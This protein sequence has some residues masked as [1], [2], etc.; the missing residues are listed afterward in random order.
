MLFFAISNTPR[1]H[2]TL[3]Y[4][5]AHPGRL[6]SIR[7]NLNR[8]LGTLIRKTEDEVKE[9][10]WIFVYFWVFLGA[11]ALFRSFVLKE[12]QILHH[13]VF[14]IMNAWIL[15]K[16]TLV[17][18]KLRIAETL[19]DRPLAFPIVFRSAVFSVI[20]VCFYA[21]EEVLIG[22]LHGKTFARSVPELAG[23][24]WTGFVVVGVLL[25]VGL[26]PFFA[27]RELASVLGKEK[28]RSLV[29]GYGSTRI[30]V[31]EDSPLGE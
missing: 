5:L 29:F 16:V 26:I 22:I 27:Y 14:A 2:I 9:L 28:L 11:F 3:Q 30:T 10:F 17:A 24:G 23:G 25:F 6:V 13:Q 7:G 15:A 19:K 20:L 18:E 21:G 8:L 31:R 12:P 1:R 4:A